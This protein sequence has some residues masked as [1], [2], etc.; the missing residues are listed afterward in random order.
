MKTSVK[1]SGIVAALMLAVSGAAMSAEQVSPYVHSSDGKIV[2]SGY[3]LCYRTGFWTPAL[4]Q[5]SGDGCN[6][7]ADIL[8][9]A[10]VEPA[11]VVQKAPEKVTLSADTLF[12]YNKAD[13]KAEGEAALDELVSK[14]AGVDVE[15]IV[16]TGYADRIGSDKFN[17]ELSQRRAESVKAYLV[18][19]G[20]DASLIQAEGRG[21]ATRSST[22]RIRPATV[23]SR[24]S[25]S[26][27]SAW[28]RTAARWSKSRVPVLRNNPDH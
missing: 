4:A 1:L 24:T 5:A 20:V 23:K 27:S 11:P 28:L 8:G 15:V 18:S 16:T 19:K 14:I 2:K 25:V 21:E 6:C 26:S 17:L 13:L 12:A 22:A 9:E 7:D 10:C 3:G